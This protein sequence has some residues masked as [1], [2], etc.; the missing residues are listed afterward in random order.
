VTQGG[1]MASGNRLAVFAI[2]AIAMSLGVGLLLWVSIELAIFA[3]VEGFV[4]P[5]RPKPAAPA[6]AEAPAPVPPPP[7]PP[8][9][10]IPKGKTVVELSRPFERFGFAA[11]A[12]FWSPQAELPGADSPDDL[13]RSKVLLYENETLLGPPHSLHG[14]VGKLGEGRYS[15]WVVQ[16]L[17]FSASDNSDPNTNGRHYWAVEP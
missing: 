7:P 11:V 15:H 17:I 10:K 9:F 5:P 4:D 8:V 13:E 14:D 12:R 3:G 1:S 6:P 2:M 16:G